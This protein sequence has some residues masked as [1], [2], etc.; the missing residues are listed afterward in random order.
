MVKRRLKDRTP[1]HG[2]QP[3]GGMVFPLISGNK[4]VKRGT[5]PVPALPASVCLAA[6][7]NPLLCFGVSRAAFSLAELPVIAMDSCAHFCKW[8]FTELEDPI[9]CWLSPKVPWEPCG[10]SL[11]PSLAGLFCGPK[12]GEEPCAPP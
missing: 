11:S 4:L 12:E 2:G 9:R 3:L 10:P 7:L 6:V 5:S 8:F 1:G